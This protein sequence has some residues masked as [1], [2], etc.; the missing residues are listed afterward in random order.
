MSPG[1][2][3]PPVLFVILASACGSPS[4][5]PTPD[6]TPE[7]PSASP[8]A[9]LESPATPAGKPGVST[10]PSA[11]SPLEPDGRYFGFLRRITAGRPVRVDFDVVQ[12]LTGEPGLRAA[13]EDGAEPADSDGLTND[14]YIRNRSPDVRSVELADDVRITLVTCV[15]ECRSVDAELSELTALL[16]GSRDERF[17]GTPDSLFDVTLR[18]GRAALVDEQ[19]L[20]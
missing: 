16:Q 5:S 10:V 18:D 4:E 15:E 19:L 12:F 2:W 6:S 20:P 8:P 17:Y 3:L 13:I 7:S 1:K 9:G 11:G 14:Y